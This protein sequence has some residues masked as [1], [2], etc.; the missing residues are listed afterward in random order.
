MCLY[1]TEPKTNTVSELMMEVGALI[2]ANDK[3]AESSA[4]R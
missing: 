3:A 1:Q 4:G 2:L